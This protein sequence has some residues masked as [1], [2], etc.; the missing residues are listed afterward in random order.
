[1][2]RVDGS[3]GSDDP[4]R[5]AKMLVSGGLGGAVSRTATA[6]LDRLRMLLQVLKR[7]SY[8]TH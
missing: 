1:M 4:W 3:G 8:D 7:A 5:T 6:P 2:T